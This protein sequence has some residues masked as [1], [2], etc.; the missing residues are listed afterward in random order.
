MHPRSVHAALLVSALCLS[1]TSA[2]SNSSNADA[3]TTDAG[4]PLPA[5]A[6]V[7]AQTKPNILLVIADD[8]GA[9][10]APCM[11]PEADRLPMPRVESLCAE[12]VVFDRVWANPTCSPT[13][14]TM[15][16]GRYSFRTGVGQQIL[17]NNTTALPTTETTLPHIL[18]PEYASAA[19]GKWHL[20][21]ASNGGV[22]HPESTGFDHYAGL[23]IGAHQDFYNWTRTEDGES[24][25]IEE[26]AT[27]RM[28]DDAIDWLNQQP[29]AKPWFLWLAYTAP[30][31]PF[32]QPPD[33]LHTQTGLTGERQ[34]IRQ[35]RAAY[36]RAAA[37]ALDTELGRL[38]DHLSQAERANT[39]VIFVGDNGTTGQVIPA[40]RN[41]ASAKGTLYEG[42]IHVPMVITGPGLVEPG[43]RVDAPVNLAD[44]YSTIAEL[45]G[46][47][48]ASLEAG[49][50]LIDSLSLVPYLTEAQTEPRRTWMY[51]ELFGS[52]IAPEREGRAVRD[53]RYKLIR[54]DQGDAV[55]FDLNEDP[56]EQRNLL[57]ADL[58]V[59]Q[60][61]A[62]DRLSNALMDLT[63]AP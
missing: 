20:A 37:Q 16:T 34:H 32:H 45:T 15:L 40:P 41:P 14:A 21:N 24:L 50:A 25:D 29:D 57:D 60:Q 22:A 55:F 19:I 8:L 31:T 3:S 36:F 4:S 30:H 10:V 27:T 13:R 56:F 6:G 49:N 47:T 52:E 18:D 12:G 59:V 46:R 44:L 35:N 61:I 54:F 39:W 43:R 63:G 42:G 17:G 58:S 28:T 48:R 1:C 9:D 51:S 33:A 26:Y 7:V 5:D 62:F 11:A 53:E 2:P 23:M 38:L